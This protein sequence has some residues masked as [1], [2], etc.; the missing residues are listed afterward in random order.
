[1]LSNAKHASRKTTLLYTF[2]VDL[3]RNLLEFN[4]SKVVFSKSLAV[5][6]LNNNKLFGSIPEEMTSLSLQLFNVSYNRLCGKIPVGGSLQRFDY[7][8]YF[9]NRCLCGAPLESCK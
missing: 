1:M 2:T 3:S 4:L 8:T 6:D 9:H 5:L 7:S